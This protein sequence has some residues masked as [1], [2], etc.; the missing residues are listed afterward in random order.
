[1][2]WIVRIDSG[3]AFS[4]VVPV[5]TRYES[6]SIVREMRGWRRM[7]AGTFAGVNGSARSS[8]APP[9]IV[10]PLKQT[11]EM[12]SSHS[13]GLDSCQQGQDLTRCRLHF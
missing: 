7:P 2:L 11:T 13:R 6:H 4:E 12:V 3:L 8:S 10:L 1:V 9:R 5:V